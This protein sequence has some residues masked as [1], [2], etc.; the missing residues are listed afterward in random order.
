MILKH[1]ANLSFGQTHY[2]RGGKG[3]RL[4]ALHASPLSSAV[5]VPTINALA[6]YS[7]I[8]APDTPGYGQSDPLPPEMLENTNDLIPY[9]EWLKEFIDSFGFKKVGL[10]G[11]ATGSQIAICFAERYPE[12]LDYVIMDS[13]AHF[14]EKERQEIPPHYFPD[15]SA[16]PDGSHLTTIW[17]MS[18]GLFN[19]FP[20]Y[21]EDEEHRIGSDPT[22]ELVDAVAKAYVTAGSDYA[23]AYSRAFRSEDANIILKV[24]QTPVRIIRWQ[25]SIVK[26]YTDRFDEFQWPNNIQMRHCGQTMD[27]RL[28]A[29]I[30]CINEFK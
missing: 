8:I 10:Y 23:Q 18:N 3:A 28:D 19:W 27:E 25:G 6:P 16:K 15:T 13:A 20:W 14:S 21:L 24:N 11:V 4:I 1:Y 26:K 17:K 2:R 9:V 7:D 5:M 30:N 12:R 29:I 22:T